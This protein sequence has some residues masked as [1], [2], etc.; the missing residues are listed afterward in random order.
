MSHRAF[1]LKDIV[2]VASVAKNHR[3]SG[4]LIFRHLF[5]FS[6]SRRRAVDRRSGAIIVVADACADAN[7]LI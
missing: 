4:N 2:F 6:F 1:V 5:D 3:V 7:M